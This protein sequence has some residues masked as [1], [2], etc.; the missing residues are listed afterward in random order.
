MILINSIITFGLALPSTV[1]SSK[2][3]DDTIR[4]QIGLLFIP[5]NLFPFDFHDSPPTTVVSSNAEFSR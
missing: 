4:S 3:A 5:Q 1:H 2:P